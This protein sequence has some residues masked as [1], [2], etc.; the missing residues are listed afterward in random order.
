MRLA[1]INT[2]ARCARN[3]GFTVAEVAIALAISALVL[4]GLIYGFVLSTK[5]AEWSAYSLAAQS[6]AIQRVEQ[7][8]AVKWDPQQWPTPP[9]QLVSASYPPVAEILDIPVTGGIF[10]YATNYTTITT[11]A[12]PAPLKMIRADCVWSFPSRGLFTNTV[13]TY[14]APDQ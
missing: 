6:L 7:T 14:R 13:I 2:S 3:Q 11:I 8:R 9:D 5:R 1:Y 10:I 4:W 12:S